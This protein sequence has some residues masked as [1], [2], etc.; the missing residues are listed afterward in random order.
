VTIEKK[1]LLHGILQK[2][3]LWVNGKHHQAVKDLGAGLSVSAR[4][5]DGVIE[6]IEGSSSRFVIG[7]QWHPEG[8]WRED[9]DSMKLFAAFINAA[10]AGARR[11]A[12]AGKNRE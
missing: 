8:N 5:P 4:A 1:T 7:V 10:R 11:G 12:L 6:G 2:E 9:A 3:T